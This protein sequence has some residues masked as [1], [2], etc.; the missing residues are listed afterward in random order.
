[1]LKAIRA[2]SGIKGKLSITTCLKAVNAT[3]SGGGGGSSPELD[4]SKASNSMYIPLLF[5]YQ[6]L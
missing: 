4:F 2:G 6:T 1:M 5:G 3:Y